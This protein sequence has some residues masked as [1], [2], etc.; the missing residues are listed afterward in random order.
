MDYSGGLIAIFGFCAFFAFATSVV[1]PSRFP[2]LR[3]RI[4]ALFGTIA[5]LAVMAVGTHI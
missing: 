4:A 3:S 5:S 1:D 2:V